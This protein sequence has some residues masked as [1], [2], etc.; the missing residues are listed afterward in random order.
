MQHLDKVKYLNKK[1]TGN[2]IN[3]IYSVYISES[4]NLDDGDSAKAESPFLFYGLFLYET[5]K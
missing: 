5:L 1:I 3:P 4:V 2:T